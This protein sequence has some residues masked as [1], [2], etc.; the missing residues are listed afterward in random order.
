MIM[1]GMKNGK[2]VDYNILPHLQEK[3]RGN[4]ASNLC[5]LLKFWQL[6]GNPQ[7]QVQTEEH[8]NQKWK[9]EK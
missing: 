8:K 6:F 2:L 9:S 1:T 5:P 4:N 7:L 3:K